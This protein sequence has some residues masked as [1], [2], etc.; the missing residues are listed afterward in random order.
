M[1]NQRLICTL[2]SKNVVTWDVKMP[3]QVV[4]LGLKFFDNKHYSLPSW[5]TDHFS[6]FATRIFLHLHL[7]C[8]LCEHICF[9]LGFQNPSSIKT[10]LVFQK[11][12]SLDI[13]P[14]KVHIFNKPFAAK[15]LSSMQF[16]FLLLLIIFHGF[17]DF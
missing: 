11:T 12:S 8:F 4:C 9:K 14:A 15:F 2:N 6:L 7:S 17:I 1:K 16:F 3:N 5:S 13:W 10:I